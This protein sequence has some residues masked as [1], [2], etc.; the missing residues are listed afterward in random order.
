MLFSYRSGFYKEIPC[1]DQASTECLHPI[2]SLS[3]DFFSVTT[4]V[5]Y[6]S[7]NFKCEF[8]RKD[9]VVGLKIANL[10]VRLKG[11]AT[12]TETRE[13]IVAYKWKVV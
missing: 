5:E 3:S 2:M 7:F 8:C 12:L 1:F 4:T 9:F 11:Y 13:K 6:M 10:R